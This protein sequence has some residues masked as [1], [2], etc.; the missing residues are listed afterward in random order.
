MPFVTTGSD[1]NHTQG[2]YNFLVIAVASCATTFKKWFKVCLHM[3]YI[4]GSS[5]SSK[6]S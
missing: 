1:T 5:F 6:M 4:P 3:D 2:N